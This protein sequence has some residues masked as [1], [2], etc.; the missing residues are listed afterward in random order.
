MP[1][2]N[3]GHCLMRPMLAERLIAAVRTHLDNAYPTADHPTPSDHPA[4]AKLIE[5]VSGL[6]A[7]VA[8]NASGP[9]ICAVRSALQ[10]LADQRQDIGDRGLVDSFLAELERGLQARGQ[11]IACRLVDELVAQVARLEHVMRSLDERPEEPAAIEAR[12]A[13]LRQCLNEALG[14][15]P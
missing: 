12:N 3:T 1:N 7:V 2:V 6:Q 4:V 5:E 11:F 8:D 14:L 10:Q 13:A 15:L 9:N